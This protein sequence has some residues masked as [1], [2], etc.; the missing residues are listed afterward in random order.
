MKTR[1]RRLSMVLCAALSALS[2]GV[3]AS[4]AMAAFQTAAFD[5]EFMEAKTSGVTVELAGGS[6]KTCTAETATGTVWFGYGLSLGNSGAFNETYFSCSGGTTLQLLTS[7]DAQYDPSTGARRILFYGSG[8]GTSP[9]GTYSY[10]SEIPS[11]YTNGSGGTLSTFS[12]NKT[13]IGQTLAG[14]KKITLTGT[15]KVN[16]GSGTVKIVP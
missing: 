13:V 10:A 16:L 5:Q 6:P 2:L 7:G 15:F 1:T 4:P 3:V 12:F 8:G 9:Y 14:A 11:P